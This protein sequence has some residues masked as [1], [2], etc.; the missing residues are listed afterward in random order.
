MGG[1]Y[2]K[3]EEQETSSINSIGLNQFSGNHSRCNILVSIPVFLAMPTKQVSI[4]HS[5]LCL[6]L[7]IK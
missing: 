5:V 3:E 4:N 2:G 1:P 6:L 7:H